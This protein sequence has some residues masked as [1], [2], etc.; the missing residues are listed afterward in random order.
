MLLHMAQIL[1]DL[2]T[3]PLTRM[4]SRLIRHQLIR[5]DKTRLWKSFLTSTC[6]HYQK[7][8]LTMKIPFILAVFLLST[9]PTEGKYTYYPNHADLRSNVRPG[10]LLL[11]TYS[12]YFNLMFIFRSPKNEA[13]GS[14]FIY[15]WNRSMEEQNI[16]VVMGSKYDARKWRFRE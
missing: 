1:S 3:Y 13:F 4:Q 15:N 2:V 16:G 14:A 9:Y 8:F 6:L 10:K 11:N 7:I 5:S 12:S